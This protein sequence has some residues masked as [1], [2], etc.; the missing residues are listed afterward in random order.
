MSASMP[1]SLN[2]RQVSF[3]ALMYGFPYKATA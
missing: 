2:K 1:R 3:A